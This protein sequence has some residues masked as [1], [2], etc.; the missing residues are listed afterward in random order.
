MQLYWRPGTAAF[1]AYAALG[2]IGLPCA[3]ILMERDSSGNVPDDYLRSNPMGQVPTL[4]DGPLVLPE[5]ATIQSAG[6]SAESRAPATS[7][8]TA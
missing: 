3:R 7:R 4:I 8:A 1:A 2:E 6:R 5:V